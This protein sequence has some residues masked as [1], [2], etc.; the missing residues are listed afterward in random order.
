MKMCM[1]FWYNAL[2]ILFLIFFWFVNLVFFFT[3]NAGA[4]SGFLNRGFRFAKGGSVWSIYP[5]VLKISHDNEIIWT[6]RGVRATSPHPVTP[7]G[8]ATEVLSKCIDSG[9]LVGATPLTVFHQLFWNFAVVF[10]MEWRCA[11]GFGIF[12]WYL[13]L[14]LSNFQLL[15]CLSP[16]CCSGDIVRSS[17]PAHDKTNKMI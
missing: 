6:K 15:I 10:C 17:E 14:Y 5:T 1:C 4:E 3:L 7:S 2:L 8:S 12:L 13:F 16:Q 11:G 9:Y